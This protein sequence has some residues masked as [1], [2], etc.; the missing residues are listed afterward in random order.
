[1]ISLALSHL[2][3]IFSIFPVLALEKMPEAPNCPVEEPKRPALGTLTYD[4]IK[5]FVHENTSIKNG[6]QFLDCLPRGLF[7]AYTLMF[8][9]SSSQEASTT[10][11]RVIVFHPGTNLV[12]AFATKG[13]PSDFVMTADLFP[14]DFEF[15][16]VSVY[17]KRMTSEVPAIEGRLKTIAS[18]IRQAE[19]KTWSPGSRSCR[20]KFRLN[21]FT[22][23]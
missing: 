6:Y 22:A 1:M 19:K 12:M 11:P 17:S 3:A 18:E 7:D 4:K 2:A 5:N 14:M 21:R 9:S 10:H 16:Q 13:K 20:R 15:I 8:N 23:S